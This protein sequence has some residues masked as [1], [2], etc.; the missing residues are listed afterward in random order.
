MLANY[1]IDRLLGRGGMASVYYGVDLQLQRPAAIKVLDNR[2][3]GDP[4][5]AD[6]FVHE[7][8]AMASWRHPNIPQVYQAGVE[9]GCS[10][11]AMEFIQGLDL[12]KLLKGMAQR[13]ERLAFEDVVLIGRAVAAALDYAHQKGAIHRDVKPSNVLIS[14]DDRILLSDFGLVLELDKGTRG[15][16]F[17]SPGYIAPEQA[18]SSSKAIPQS[19]L[20]ALGVMLY[21]MLVGRLPFED[22]SP[23]SLALSH[24][25]AEPPAPRQLNPDLSPE[26]EAVLLKALRKVPEERYPTGKALMDALEAAAPAPATQLHPPASLTQPAA[27][28]PAL[29]GPGE[30]PPER[31]ISRLLTADLYPTA[32]YPIGSDAAGNNRAGDYPAR[33]SP[34]GAGSAP[35][36]RSSPE[37]VR[38]AKPRLKAVPYRS[39]CLAAVL[40]GGVLSLL[41]AAVLVP[42]WL[43]AIQGRLTPTGMSAVL[44]T[45]ERTP[46]YTPT[47]AASPTRAAPVDPALPTVPKA[48]PT[49]T[50]T[51]QPTPTGEPEYLVTIA[52]REDDSMFVINHS[53]VD[54]PLGFIRFGSGDRQFSGEEWEVEFL[55]P[56]QCVS[57]WKTEGNPK[58][59]KGIRCETVGERLERSGEG[60]FWGSAF[61]VYFQDT[62][63]EVCER[64]ESVCELR[65]N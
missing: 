38:G 25:T 14:E 57:I 58:A 34:A 55:K 61:E 17:G 40:A 13:G 46:A 45:A 12:D 44:P 8:R 65:F 7:A 33:L 43:N 29:P 16:V 6:R 60:K 59:P 47:A 42:R 35:S 50:A 31:T 36:T 53:T 30:N 26:I 2:H 41:C 19:D 24:M 49:P 52:K 9:G 21:E 20:Y 37:P 32:P 39:F 63:V 23:A 27:T 62:P 3:S 11:Y 28:L 54:L 48:P 51:Q 56:G 18:R 10:F 64:N 22:A 5:Y 15:E 4:A 1:R